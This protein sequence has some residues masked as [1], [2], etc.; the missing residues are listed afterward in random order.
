M[1][2][3]N[4]KDLTTALTS[5]KSAADT[6][7][8]LRYLLGGA[9]TGGGVAALYNYIKDFQAQAEEN[10]DDDDE[11]SGPS[12]NL[13]GLDKASSENYGDGAADK[14]LRWGGAGLGLGLGYVGV[15]EIYDRIKEKRLNQELEDA[16]SD[17]MESLHSKR[18]S[19]QNKYASLSKEAIVDTTLA[20]SGGLLL[21]LALASG[22]I[23]NKALGDAFPAVKPQGKG[24]DL[25]GR[26]VAIKRRK[27]SDP[28]ANESPA[29][30]TV[31]D[32]NGNEVKT[33][34]SD[35][36]SDARDDAEEVGNLIRM[37]TADDAISK[38]AGFEDL[39]NAVAMGRSEEIKDSIPYGVNQ[40]FQIVK[41]AGLEQVS[42]LSRE[43]AIEV[44]AS[45]PMMKEAF[46]PVFAS[47]YYEMS[48]YI[49]E[50]AMKCDSDTKETLLKV[51]RHFN[52]EYRKSVFSTNNDLLESYSALDKSAATSV[53]TSFLKEVLSKGH[54][55]HAS[56]VESTEAVDEEGAEEEGAEEE[57]AE[58]ED[59]VEEPDDQPDM[60]D[61]MLA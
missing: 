18:E 60:I 55:F 37:T 46:A 33:V 17:Y 32:D 30:K 47:E 54:G 1:S 34:S 36:S 50:S 8:A 4:D 49:V 39:I 24:G 43:L 51:A 26:P 45:D 59:M 13:V 56:G 6:S 61:K 25:G 38:K 3:N 57:G 29:E 15:K 19:E 41:G 48:P 31:L 14:L 7:N 16:Q 9:L 11:V 12:V 2:E 44:I 5:I 22:V 42:P 10:E 53:P 27:R 21:A 58:V 20:T 40:V 23:T 28:M 52:A 35:K